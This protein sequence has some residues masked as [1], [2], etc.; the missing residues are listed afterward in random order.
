[1]PEPGWEGASCVPP[2]VLGRLPERV[3]LEFGRLKSPVWRA[4][5]GQSGPAA[6]G[7]HPGASWLRPP[8]ARSQVRQPAACHPGHAPPEPEGGPGGAA[9]SGRPQ[10]LAPTA[11]QARW[12][13]GGWSQG[14]R[15]GTGPRRRHPVQVRPTGTGSRGRGLSPPDRVL[16]GAGWRRSAWPRASSSCCCCSASTA[17]SARA[18]TG[19]PAGGL[20]GGAAGTCP[21]TTTATR[22]PRRR[23]CPWCCA[24]TSW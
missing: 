15:H 21:V 22:R 5:R 24:G 3:V 10:R 23:S 2:P 19:S 11:A 8:A 4:G 17:C 16:S 12:A 20:A 13:L 7:T 9:P 1:M 6:G 18:T 14:A